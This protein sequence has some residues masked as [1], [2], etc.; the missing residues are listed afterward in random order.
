VLHQGKASDNY[1]NR[2]AN[3]EA[4]QKG[5]AHGDTTFEQNQWRLKEQPHTN[6]SHNAKKPR[7]GGALVA[8]QK[9]EMSTSRQASY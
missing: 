4:D 1:S 5:D 3:D 2:Q 6:N 8:V 7:F 9:R